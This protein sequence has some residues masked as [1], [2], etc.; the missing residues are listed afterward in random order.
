MNRLYSREVLI[1]IRTLSV[2]TLLKSNTDLKYYEPSV[3]L[4]IQKEVCSS[5][6]LD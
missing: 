5:K 2:L 3:I 6:L 4:T 1:A